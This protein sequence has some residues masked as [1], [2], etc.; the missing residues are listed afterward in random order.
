M[1][2]VKRRQTAFQLNRRVGVKQAVAECH[3]LNM[4]NRSWL[5]SYNVR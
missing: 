3:T 2:T 1:L 5:K 4:T